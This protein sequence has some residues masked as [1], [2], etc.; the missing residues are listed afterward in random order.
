MALSKHRLKA[1]LFLLATAALWGSGFVAQR[2]AMEDIG[3]LSFTGIRFFLG[4]LCIQPLV[5]R[6][7][8]AERRN[9]NHRWLTISLGTILLIGVVLQQI[10]IQ[11]TTASKAGFLTCICVILTPILASFWSHKIAGKTWGGAVL[12]LTGMYFL[13]MQGFRMQ[14]G[15]ALVTLGA[16]MWA[17][18]VLLLD[19]LAK[20]VPPALLASRQFLLVSICSTAYALL[21][22]EWHV[23]PLLNA[24]PA[25]L[26]SGFFSIGAAFTLQAYAQ[27]HT[28][29]S[30]AAIIMSTESIFAALFGFLLLGEILNQRELFG[31]ALVLTGVVISQL[32]WQTRVK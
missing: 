26:Y 4:W 18:H 32:N 20:R 29:A 25:I 9:K 10:G 17:G 24:A 23:E 30:D 6:I 2:V 5:F 1:D 14:M 22:E 31:C 12:V 15:D 16:C 19:H 21:F 11:Y 8:P 27:V 28:P 7:S 3:P 13:S